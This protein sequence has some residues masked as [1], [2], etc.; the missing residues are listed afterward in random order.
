MIRG[1]P[2]ALVS[3]LSL[4][5]LVITAATWIAS[6]IDGITVSDGRLLLFHVNDP[7]GNFVAVERARANRTQAGIWRLLQRN[8]GTWHERFGLAY[9]SGKYTEGF[10][11][12]TVYDG[13]LLDVTFKVIAIPF[14]LLSILLAVLPCCWVMA[15]SRRRTRAATG[16]CLNCGYDVRASTDR[17]PECGTAITPA[18]RVTA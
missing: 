9:G 3:V 10:S 1:R 4:L 7:D 11:P 15:N 14:W 16:R 18:G 5:L 6:W 2:L 8:A 13:T 17:C 12:T